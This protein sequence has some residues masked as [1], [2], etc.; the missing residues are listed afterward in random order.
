MLKVIKRMPAL[1]MMLAFFLLRANAQ[2]N[3]SDHPRWIDETPKGYLNDYFIGIGTSDSSYSD[4]HEKALVDAIYRIQQSREIVVTASQ[5]D[6]SYLIQRNLNNNQSIELVRKSA[7]ELAIDG[8]SITIRG[9]IEEERYQETEGT[10]YTFW[11]LVKIPKTKG[12]ESPPSSFSPVW[13]ST[14]LPGWGQLY[15]GQNT[16][17]FLIAGTEVILVSAAFIFHNLK[18][19][20]K[21]DAE[22]SRTQALRDYYNDQ[23]NLYEDISLGCFIAAGAIYIFNISDA[24]SSEGEKV[25]VENNKIKFEFY[26]DYTTRSS[27]VTLSIRI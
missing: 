5:R 25:Y 24:I 18:L 16:K 13:R 8:K 22:N 6:T 17:G 11:S 12:F 23:T 21:T 7:R 19:T 26:S 27:K 3:Q 20:A 1:I 14:L 10:S 9:L 15:K 2:S 4:A